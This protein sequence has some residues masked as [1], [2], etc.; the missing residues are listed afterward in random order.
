MRSKA[1]ASAPI[2]SRLRT[3]RSCSRSPSAI[4]SAVTT[5]RRTR[6][7]HGGE[8]GEEEV[9]GQR[10][11]EADDDVGAARGGAQV[12]D[13][14]GEQPVE[15]GGEPGLQRGGGWRWRPCR[16]CVAA[17]PSGPRCTARVSSSVRRAGRAREL[18]E[19]RVEGRAERRVGGVRVG[20]LEAGGDGVDG[21][22]QHAL[23]DRER[24]PLGLGAVPG[25]DHRRSRGCSRARRSSSASG[26]L[27]TSASIA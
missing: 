17:V 4:A 5:M 13:A 7:R 19:G 3:P 26:A 11:A 8:E 18:R 20:R 25:G 2:S 27:L 15:R 21:A 10:D 22:R 6:A 9:G 12:V 1:W 24:D 16:R 14:G 23:V